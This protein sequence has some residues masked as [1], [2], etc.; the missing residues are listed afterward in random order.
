[1]YRNSD[2]NGYNPLLNPSSS[3]SPSEPSFLSLNDKKNLLDE[4]NLKLFSSD[5]FIIKDETLNN[6]KIKSSVMNR[7]SMDFEEVESIMWRKVTTLFLYFSLTHSIYLTLFLSLSDFFFS[8]WLQSLLTSL[9]PP[10]FNSFFSFFS[11]NYEDSFKIVVIGGLLQDEE[12][13]GN[14]F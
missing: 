2:S 14:G 13:L 10:I 12:P 6:L 1:M 4:E 3:S 7:E 5:H 9:P 8:F 11:I